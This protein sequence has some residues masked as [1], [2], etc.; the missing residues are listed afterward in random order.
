MESDFFL[1]SI[2]RNLNVLIGDVAVCSDNQTLSYSELNKYSRYYLEQARNSESIYV[3]VITR[4]SVLTYA[5]MIG[6]WN[7]GKAYVPIP[8][9][10][11]EDRKN[12]IIEVA[13][14][15]VVIDPMISMEGS[16]LISYPD[17]LVHR[18][19]DSPAYLLF[20]SGSSGRPK[21]V[22]ISFNNLQAFYEGFID[23]DY[24]LNSD[25]R[26]L[27]MFELTFDLS[28]MSWIIPLT[29]GASF[30][31]LPGNLSKALG[32]YKILFEKGITFALM[33]PSVT[34]LLLPFKGEIALP[35]LKIIQFCGEALRSSDV[36]FWQA[37]CPEAQIDNVYGPT[38][39]TIYCSRYSV[40]SDDKPLTRGEW[41]SIGKPMKFVDFD[42][43]L[44]ELGSELIIV[45][46][47]VSLGYLVS[48]SSQRDSFYFGAKGHSYCSGDLISIDEI[49]GN[50]FYLGRI[51]EQVKIRGHRIE[52][53]EIE[54]LLREVFPKR[55]IVAFDLEVNN[56]L[57]LVVVVELPE[58]NRE[59]ID[60]RSFSDQLSKV[61]PKYM[62][63]DHIFGLKYFPLNV[64][65]KISKSELRRMVTL[66]LYNGIQ[67]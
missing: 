17:F 64:N 11:P 38:E 66:N 67:S 8:V 45:G 34:S 28:V 39:A 53:G 9:D 65:G 12:Y 3:G 46:K 31:T 40:P 25:D 33:V 13:N 24:K 55:K 26:F 6:I 50:Y 22:P 61:L 30:F 37:V 20:T 16:E 32:L 36:D 27:Q 1:N 29:L 49:S 56:I 54:F 63:P 58:E 44:N 47:Q 19:L 42:T 52:L 51:D 5:A 43:Q 62:L 14:L 59:I 41:V 18:E 4:N 57:E 48:N 35:K 21:G 60:L 2:N 10:Y 23:L 7:A 15:H